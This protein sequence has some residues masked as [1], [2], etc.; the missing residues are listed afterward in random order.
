[1]QGSRAV[2]MRRTEQYECKHLGSPTVK[3]SHVR[4]MRVKAEILNRL[5]AWVCAM[6]TWGGAPRSY[7]AMHLLKLCPLCMD[8]LQM[9]ADFAPADH[10]RSPRKD[11]HCS[12]GKHIRSS[13]IELTRRA[14]AAG[15]CVK[16]GCCDFAF[17]QVLSFGVFCTC[18]GASYYVSH[19][20]PHHYTATSM[21][22]VCPL[23]VPAPIRLL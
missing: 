1:M 8:S 14:L 17:L 20:Q 21:Q 12:P 7:S 2:H 6:S 5:K 11:C 23:C 3:H 9:P 19:L 4:T 16:S 13:R 15:T 22:L 10:L 18:C